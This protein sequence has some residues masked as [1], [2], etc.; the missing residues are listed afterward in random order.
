VVGRR[1]EILAVIPARGGSQGI[2]RKNVRNLAGHP[3]LA[4]SIAAGQQANTVTRVIVSTDDAEIADF[5]REYGAD[6]PFVR[7][8][9][10]AHNDT[11]DLPVFQ[12]AIEWLVE[13]E[14][15]EAEIV[16]QLRPTSPLRAPGL[17]DE[18]VK[19][20]LDDAAADS[21]RTVTPPSQNPYKMWSI[22]NG[23][24]Q[25]LL[26]IDLHEPYNSPRQLLPATYWQTGHID[27]F[28]TRTV[29]EKSS[30]T[31][32]R[33][34]PVIVDSAYAVDIDS[35][36]QLEIA[37]AIIADGELALVRPSVSSNHNQSKGAYASSSNR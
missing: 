5:A 27:A 12:H 23:V 2:R 33:I 34:L 25:P 4:W 6:V 26:A 30:L 7:P 11:R 22:R 37:S 36:T 28:R 20:L 16:V 29:R 13:N 9:E 3:L 14:G 10:L 17:V 18:A 8:R 1:P 21:A 24:L 32:D 31:G 15:Y 35:L 19:L